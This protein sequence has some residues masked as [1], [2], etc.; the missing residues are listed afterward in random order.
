MIEQLNTVASIL[1][2]FTQKGW[3]ISNIPPTHDALLQHVKRAAY[4][5][6][7]VWSQTLVVEPA[8]PCPSEWGWHLEDSKWHPVWMTILEAGKCCP[9][10]LRCGCKSGCTTRKF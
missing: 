4:Q 3:Q 7:H 10:L 1:H 2:F 6:G 5:T 8:L 9:E